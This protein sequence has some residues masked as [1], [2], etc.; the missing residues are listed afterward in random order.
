Q[1]AIGDVNEPCCLLLSDGSR[2]SAGGKSCSYCLAA[3]RGDRRSRD[4]RQCA[5]GGVLRESE[6]LSVAN[7][8]RR[9]VRI[10]YVNEM[11]PCAGDDA[12][13]IVAD[14]HSGRR[15]EAVVGVD[16]EDRNAA[17]SG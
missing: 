15:A 9:D 12:H 13:R 4:G 17:R 11:V 8:R 5:G 10:E 6:D 7:T 2:R 14:V 1:T 16:R 3:Y